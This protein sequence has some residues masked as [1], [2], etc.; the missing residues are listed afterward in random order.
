MIGIP[1]VLAARPPASTARVRV[2]ARAPQGAPEPEVGTASVAQRI[3]GRRLDAGLRG[4]GP[5]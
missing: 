4:E 3:R 1:R 5:A 2:G